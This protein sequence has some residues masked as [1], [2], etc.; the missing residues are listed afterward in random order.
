MLSI[1]IASDLHIDHKN[2]TVPDPLSYITPSA[3]ILL[4]SGDIGSL[5][6]MEQLYGFLK[7]VCNY[8][9][10]VL[11]VPGNH[12]WYIPPNYE[13]LDWSVLENRLESLGYKINNLH[14]LYRKTVRFDK[15][16]ITGATLW[17]K[18][19][20]RIPPFII[21][22]HGMNTGIYT[23][24]H[25]QDLNYIKQMIKYCSK[26]NYKL[27][28]ATHHPPTKKV[29]RN[30]R[31]QDKFS[32]LYYTDLE[33]LLNKEKVHTWIYGHVHQNY[34]FYTEKGCRVVGNQLG[35]PKENISGYQKNFVLE[36]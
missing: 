21:K 27:V 11:Y 35:K 2:N 9:K 18:P 25:I 30:N 32:S 26:H 12:E 10:I 4:L 14:I 22:I 34:D 6:K 19:Q 17:S 16:C 7:A 5:Y 23:R 29:T 8:F 1:Q 28:V 15:V 24:N 13:P 36:I 3:D 33:Y 20:S 31:K